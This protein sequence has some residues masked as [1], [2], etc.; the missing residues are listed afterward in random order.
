MDD[1]SVSF[2]VSRHFALGLL[3]HPQ[4]WHLGF[5]SNATGRPGPRHPT[6]DARSIKRPNF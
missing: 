5:L 2:A 1:I 3:H 6:W 4:G